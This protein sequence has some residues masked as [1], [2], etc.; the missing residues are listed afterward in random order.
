[1]ALIFLLDRVE[2]DSDIT[3]SNVTF[4]PGKSSLLGMLYIRGDVKLNNV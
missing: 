2:V 1:M 3:L 4:R